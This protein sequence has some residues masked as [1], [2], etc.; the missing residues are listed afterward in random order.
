[1]AE[2]LGHVAMGLLFAL[3]AWALWDG[4]TAG[5]F[6]AFV[7]L[8]SKL[9]DLD[10]KLQD[11]GLPVEH[12]G[13]L[14][15]VVF[16][17]GFSLVAGAVA[18]AVLRPVLRRW[19]RLTEDE[20]VRTGTVYLFVTGG[21]V[22]GG[23]SHLFADALAADPYEPIEP[24]WPFFREPVTMHVVHYTSTALNLGLLIVAVLLHAAVLASGAFP[25]EHQFRRWKGPL[26]PG[27]SERRSS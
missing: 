24:L 27:D 22:L 1:M 13:V 21:F 10:L 18:T 17:V 20:T 2:L 4:R 6:V 15:T 5:A 11:L 25:L 9:P 26:P 7:L 19:W 23:L 12:H 8:T 16:V 14:H 3:P